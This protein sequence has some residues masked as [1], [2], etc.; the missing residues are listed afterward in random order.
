MTGSTRFAMAVHLLTVLGYLERKGVELV[1]SSKIAVSVNTHAVVIRN[2]IRVLK[3]AGL[4][5][6]KEGKG[7]GLKLSKNPAKITLREIFEAVENDGIIAER[8]KPVFSPCPISRGMKS[9]FHSIAND[10][11][12]AVAGVLRDKTLKTII[13][14]F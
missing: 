10:V 2:L 1:P 7:G 14:Q 8:D 9:V 13:D 5:E 6:S 4:V 12:A 3:D 11:D